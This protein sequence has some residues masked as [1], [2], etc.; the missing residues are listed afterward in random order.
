M[1][2]RKFFTGNQLKLIAALSMLMDHVGAY[3]LPQYEILRIAGRISFPIF[4]Y[5]IAEGCIYTKNRLR[6]LGTMAGAAAV[7]QIFYFVATGSLYQCVFVTFSLS[8]FLCITF[9]KARAKDSLEW[10]ILFS[11]A[12]LFVCGVT[13]GLPILLKNTDFSVDYGF[14]GAVIPLAVFVGKEKKD[15]LLIFT[16]FLVILAM[17]YD[18]V[19]F[20]SLAAVPF[21][22][23]YNGQRGKIKLKSFFYVFYPVHLVV[24]HLINMFWG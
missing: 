17:H 16:L 12:V 1:N 20:F 3:L 19:Q 11:M 5:M 2:E 9:D 4:A 8:I 15:K 6:Y 10:W 22:G 23:L 18:Y 13:D 21:V 14:W 24:I 7:F